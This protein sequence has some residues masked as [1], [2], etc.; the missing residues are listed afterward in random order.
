MKILIAG[1]AGF[2]GSHLCEVLLARDH[3]IFCVDNLSTG[4]IENI[5]CI[6]SPNFSFIRGDICDSQLILPECQRIYH[7]ASPASPI[8]FSQRPIETALANSAG[9]HNLLELAHSWG[10]RLLFAST[11]EIYG[12]PEEHPQKEDYRGNVSTIGPRSCYDESKRYGEALLMA[13]NRERGT[14]IRIVRI[15]N[16]YGPRMQ[17][18]DGRVIP[19]LVNQALTGKP[20]TIFGD[21]SQTRS[22]CFVSD[23]VEIMIRVMEGPY[24]QPFNIG[25]PEELSI[26]QV[27][28]LIK[29]ILQVEPELAYLPLPTDDPTRRCPNIDRAQKLLDWAP[30]VAFEDGLKKTIDWFQKQKGEKD[31]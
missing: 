19:A 5:S 10:A 25:R 23:L 1:G 17:W 9:C 6:N 18:D 24:I 8:Q 21:G 3:E 16:T 15:F 31:N 27:A 4:C 20:M 14:D 26:L 2:I 13:Y 7:L 22:F 29:N 12:E 30:E 11:S 28:Q